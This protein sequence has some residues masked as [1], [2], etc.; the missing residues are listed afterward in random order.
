M[1]N[2]AQKKYLRSLA[3]DCKPVIWIGQHGLTDNVME[4]INIALDHHELIKIKLRVGEREEREKVTGDICTKTKAETIQK[5]GNTLTL[6][7]RNDETPV[8]QF[9]K[10]K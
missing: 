7:R 9:P 6:Y 1:I 2:K 5:I 3:H 10:I 4:E 8:I